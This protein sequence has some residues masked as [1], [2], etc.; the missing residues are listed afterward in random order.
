MAATSAMLAYFID[1]IRGLMMMPLMQ[2]VRSYS[3]PRRAIIGAYVMIEKSSIVGRTRAMI[4]IAGRLGSTS[5]GM[6]AYSL[7]RSSDSGRGLMLSATA[8]RVGLTMPCIL[9]T[10]TFSAGSHGRESIAGRAGASQ[11]AL[12]ADICRFYRLPDR[13]R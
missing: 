8:S 1:F 4:A 12:R 3:L 5:I 9:H 10:N 11:A 13:L 6:H 7:P 2:E